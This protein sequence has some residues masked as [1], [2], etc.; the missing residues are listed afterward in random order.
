MKALLMDDRLPA[1]VLMSKSSLELCSAMLSHQITEEILCE[2]WKII[3]NFSKI[4]LFLTRIMREIFIS[5]D[6]IADFISFILLMVITWKCDFSV[7]L[8]ILVG[9][10]R[11]AHFK[12]RIPYPN[13]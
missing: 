4:V 5:S 3:R 1:V 7:D 10:L 12:R 9:K 8:I 6:N 13:L 11:N 2:Y